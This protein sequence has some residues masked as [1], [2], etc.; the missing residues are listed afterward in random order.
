MYNTAGRA[1]SKMRSTGNVI[2]ERFNDNHARSQSSVQFHSASFLV[3]AFSGFW[4]SAWL[5]MCRRNQLTLPRNDCSDLTST[6]LVRNTMCLIFSGQGMTR[7]LPLIIPRNLTYLQSKLTFWLRGILS[8]AQILQTINACCFA[9]STP[10]RDEVIPSSKYSDKNALPVHTPKS[11]GRKLSRSADW[12][13]AVDNPP[14][15]RSEH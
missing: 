15:I 9:S 1:G 3:S 5:G 14:R 4:I 6:G 13:S 2:S 11:P 12:R 7:P 10:T 8:I